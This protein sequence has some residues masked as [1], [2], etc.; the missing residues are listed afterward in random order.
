M[1]YLRLYLPAVLLMSASV[2]LLKAQSAVDVNIGFG[3]AHVGVEW[4]RPR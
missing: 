2:P 3:T 1:T 4:L